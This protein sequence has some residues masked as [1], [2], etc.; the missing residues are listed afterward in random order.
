MKAMIAGAFLALATLTGSA[1]A[2]PLGSVID[3]QVGGQGLVTPVATFVC[4][5]DD[6]GWHY[7]RGHRR[8]TCR[9]AR[10]RGVG[11][12]WH[13]EGRRCGWWHARDHRW[14]D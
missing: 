6:R 9:P 7:M 11:W 13:C 1:S 2:A 3:T 5:R 4:R 8:V 12:G 14:G 10:P